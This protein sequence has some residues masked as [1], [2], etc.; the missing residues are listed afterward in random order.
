MCG[1]AA[2]PHPEWH[3][4]AMA[5]I[6]PCQGAMPR[7][8]EGARRG[9]SGPAVGLGAL[10]CVEGPA[11]PLSDKLLGQVG[12]VWEGVVLTEPQ[13]GK[14]LRELS[15]LKRVLLEQRRLRRKQSLF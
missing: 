13:A 9:T 11:P 14:P 5:T 3:T 6:L 10:L 7:P 1:Q 15:L 4:G 2:S 8:E 12:R